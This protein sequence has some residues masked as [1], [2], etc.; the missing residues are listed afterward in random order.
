MIGNNLCFKIIWAIEKSYDIF[1]T[2]SNRPLKLDTMELWNNL[3]NSWTI[4]M[5]DGG[6]KKGKYYMV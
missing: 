2:L 6:L 5:Y 4:T 1:K 3:F